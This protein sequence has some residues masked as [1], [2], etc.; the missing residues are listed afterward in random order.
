[1]EA[2]SLRHNRDASTFLAGVAVG[3]FK[4]PEDI[5]EYIE[6]DEETKPNPQNSKIYTH[7]YKIYLDLY[8]KLRENMHKLAKT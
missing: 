4:K 6:I 5:R 2:D 1:M 7:L 8:P 3:V